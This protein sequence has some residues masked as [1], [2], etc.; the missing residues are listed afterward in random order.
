MFFFFFKLL[1]SNAVFLIL[2]LMINATIS[3]KILGL[4]MIDSYSHFEFNNAIM[5]TLAMS[6]HEV[7]IISTTK[8]KNPWANMTY[9]Q[10]RDKKPQHV[11]PW[12]AEDLKSL[13]WWKLFE[14]FKAIYQE[15]CKQFMALQ[16]T[17]VS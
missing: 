4:L 3:A 6:G 13:S 10:A 9:I 12:S 1:Q 16:D 8:P 7:T 14:I 15:D 2:A 5:E 17:Q 11:S